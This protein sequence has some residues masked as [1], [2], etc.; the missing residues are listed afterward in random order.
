MVIQYFPPPIPEPAPAPASEPEFE[1]EPE[2]EPDP[3]PLPNQALPPRR[4][5]P[6]PLLYLPRRLRRLG[7]ELHCQALLRLRLLLL[8]HAPAGHRLGVITS[9]RWSPPR[10]PIPLL[11]A[12]IRPCLS[13]VHC[14]SIYSISMYV[15]CGCTVVTTIVVTSSDVYGIILS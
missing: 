12:R 6:G 5:V 13:I 7:R 4:H 14:A 11:S 2:P 9:G 1:P 15:Y 8:H 10:R 3:N